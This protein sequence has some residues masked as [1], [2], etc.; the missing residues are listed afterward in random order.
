MFIL[1]ALEDN[2]QGLLDV[3]SPKSTRFNSSALIVT[4]TV[5]ALIARAAHS[6]RSSTPSDG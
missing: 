4:V 6:G 1:S 5:D 2:G 3:S